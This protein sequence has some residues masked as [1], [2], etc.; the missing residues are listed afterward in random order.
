MY[1]IL[2]VEN[3]SRCRRETKKT[4]CLSFLPSFVLVQHCEILPSIAL[5]RLLS[6]ER[7]SASS[8]TAAHAGTSADPTHLSP[9]TL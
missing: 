7:V 4:G 3:D 9:L 2:L 6:S 8:F 1:G 5:F